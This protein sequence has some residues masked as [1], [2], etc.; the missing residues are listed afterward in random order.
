MI[1]ILSPIKERIV[2]YLENQGV[3]KSIFFKKTGISASNF[4][5]LGAKSE[6]G[7]DKIVKII[8]VFENINPA[9]LL[10]G[11]GN[12]LKE[13]SSNQNAKALLHKED[14]NYT[15]RYLVDHN[16]ELMQEELFRQY[17]KGNI[18]FLESEKEKV[19]YTEEMNK[20]REVIL[21]KLK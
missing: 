19:K 6:L 8:T 12:M 11:E 1:K 20:L 7:G 15:I 5:G 3:K 9:W 4:K 10:T 17:I 16:E 14:I 18:K 21:K 2:F 13:D